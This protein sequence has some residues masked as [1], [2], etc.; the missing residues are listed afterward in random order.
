M[1]LLIIRYRIRQCVIFRPTPSDPTGG[2]APGNNMVELTV[3]VYDGG[4]AGGDGNL[5][6]MTQYGSGADVRVTTYGYDFRDR[7][8]Y[9]D[10]EINFYEAYT[11][12][13]VDRLLETQN[14]NTSGSGNLIAQNAT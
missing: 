2:G 9:T 13:N 6:S 12:D 10:G 5:T 8:I 7:R 1:R 11:Y 3:N 4:S 14:Y